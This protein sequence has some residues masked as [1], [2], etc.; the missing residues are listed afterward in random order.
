M[1]TPDARRHTLAGTSSRHV[2]A[3]ATDRRQSEPNPHAA[4][5]E[6]NALRRR[7]SL[8]AEL[9]NER[10]RLSALLADPEAERMPLEQDFKGL[11]SKLEKEQTREVAAV[12]QQTQTWHSELFDPR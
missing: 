11:I 5:A 7:S 8:L 4:T 3:D 2:H 12:R 10:R 6:K 9:S 1:T